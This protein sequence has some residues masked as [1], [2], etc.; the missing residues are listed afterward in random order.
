METK[1]NS[2]M[3]TLH[4]LRSVAFCNYF[5]YVSSSRRYQTYDIQ[6]THIPKETHMRLTP[7]YPQDALHEKRLICMRMPPE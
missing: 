2:T 7:L 4:M 6:R 3:K 5:E 1:K